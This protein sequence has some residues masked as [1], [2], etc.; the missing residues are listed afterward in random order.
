MEYRA[1]FL[2]DWSTSQSG[3]FSASPLE[4]RILF[5]WALGND[6]VNDFS[7]LLELVEDDGLLLMGPCSA[8]QTLSDSVRKA[9]TA[10]VYLQCPSNQ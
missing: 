10:Y 8:A 1:C 7:P 4:V 6:F 5:L 3:F 2:T 9:D